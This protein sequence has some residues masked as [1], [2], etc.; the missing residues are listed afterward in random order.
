MKFF[1]SLIRTWRESRYLEKVCS[2]AGIS[3]NE[4]ESQCVY[5]KMTLTEM[6]A[7]HKFFGR[8]P[9]PDHTTVIRHIGVDNLIAEVKNQQGLVPTKH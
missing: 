7:Y 8:L 5:F 4:L 6:M 2:S 9:H 1:K 3:P